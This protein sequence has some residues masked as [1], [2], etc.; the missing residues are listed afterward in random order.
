MSRSG[1]PTALIVG[2]GIGGLAAAVALR[3]AG[4]QCRIFERAA[5]AAAPGFGLVLA[6]NAM[7]AL[8]ELGLA[9]AISADGV[10]VGAVEIRRSNGERLRRF[11]VPEKAARPRW[12]T[13]AILRPVL[14]QR[15]LAEVGR[16]TLAFDR[17]AVDFETDARVVLRFADGG[18]E[19]GDI[20]VGADGVASVIR[21][22]LHPHEPAPVRSRFCAVRGVV[23]DVQA[24]V[25]GLT[26]VGYLGPGIEAAM[27]RSGERAVYWYMSMLDA[28][29]P[30]DVG[31]VR[32]LV[33]HRA[34]E[35]DASFRALTTATR[36]GDLRF[37]RLRER[38]PLATWGAGRVTL[39]G[40][41]AH[42]MLPHT[43]QGAAQ[44]LED[45]VGL[46]LALRGGCDEVAALRQYEQVRAAR[47]RQV[48]KMGPRLARISTTRSRVIG[49]VRNLAVRL[50]PEGLLATLAKMGPDPH[51]K[52]RPA[53]G[54]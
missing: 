13:T 21:K 36:D 28:E 4:W 39:L 6:P 15:L 20:L 14:H 10:P 49:G 19:R 40:D 22:R 1:P 2:A 24:C 47:T 30:V 48:V 16:D 34:L 31:D 26:A 33:D 8:D 18:T 7:A 17:E 44:A 12:T 32:G 35:F 43:G 50:V 3:R 42:P 37:D 11:D 5:A 27:V 9:P 41:A 54:S 25:D 52:L 23:Y 46:G 53:S 51:R 29:L 38:R 45:A